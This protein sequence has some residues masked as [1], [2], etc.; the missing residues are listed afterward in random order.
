M[1]C[2]TTAAR[3]LQARAHLKLSSSSQVASPLLAALAII[4]LIL[5]TPDSPTK[6]SSS[7][8]RPLVRGNLHARTAA[9]CLD[10]ASA[11]APAACQI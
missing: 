1:L 10:A 4:S 8:F 7:F 3:V 2:K 9:S 6:G 5:R 11:C